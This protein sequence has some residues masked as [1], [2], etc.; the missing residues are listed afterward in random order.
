MTGSGVDIKR[1]FLFTYVLQVTVTTLMLSH[2]CTV[3]LVHS[4]DVSKAWGENV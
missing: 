2:T 3:D 4:Q 1:A